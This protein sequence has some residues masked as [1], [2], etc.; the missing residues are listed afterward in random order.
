LYYQLVQRA[1]RAISRFVNKTQASTIA[2]V[3]H[4]LLAAE[5]FD[6]LADLTDALKWKLA[7]L[8]IRWTHDDLNAAYRLV[9]TARPLPGPELP[10]RVRHVER[11]PDV[12][13][14]R[15]EAAAMLHRLGIVL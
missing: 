12:T 5:Q 10:R 9:V 6:T 2:R 3:V 4:T 7:T 11:E 14:S 8:H 1:A 13:I 15:H